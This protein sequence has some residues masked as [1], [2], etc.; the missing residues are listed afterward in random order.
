VKLTLLTFLLMGWCT[1]ALCQTG[2]LTGTILDADSK[3]SLEFATINIL[4]ADSTLV[5]YKLTDKEGKFL[6]DKLPVRRKLFV[7]VTYTG[8]SEYRSAIELQPGK[9]DTLQ[10][11]LTLNTK[12]SNGV[13]VTAAVPVRMNGDTLEINPAAFKMKPDAVVEEL[14]NQVGGVVIWSDGSIT[15]NGRKVQNLMVDGKPFMGSTD[16]RVATQN[17]PKAAIDKIQLYQEYDRSNISS[18]Q[19][20]PQDSVLTMNIK[21]KEGSKKGYFGKAGGGLGTSQRFESDLSFQVYNKQ[22]SAGIGGGYNNI[23][24]SIGNLQELF[25]NNTYRNYNPNL[26]NVGRFGES[27]IN[28]NH[29]IGGVVT[30]SFIKEA[31]GR[32]NNRLAVN[33]IKSGVSS[34]ITDLSLQN[35]TTINNPQFI[36]EEGVVNNVTDKHDVGINYLKTNSYSDNLSVNGA[37]NTTSEWANSAQL[38]EVRD[39]MNMLQSTNRSTSTQHRR[40]DNE[41][42]NVDFSKSDPEEPLNSYSLRLHANRG[43]TTS[44]RDVKSVFESLV[45]RSKNTLYNRHYNVD[46]QLVNLGATLDYTGFKRMLLG[47]YNLFGINLAFS[48]QINYLQQQ[49]DNRVADFDSTAKKF[50]TNGNLTYQNKRELREYMPSLRLSKDINKW[51][52]LFSRYLGFQVSIMEDIKSDKNSSTNAKRNLDRSFQFFR[53][54]GNINYQYNKQQKYRAYT[55][56]SYSKNFDYPTIDQLYTIVDDINVYDTR[57]GNPFLRNRINHNFYLLGNFNTENPGAVYTFSG[58]LTGGYNRSRYPIV[59]STINDPSGRRINYYINGDKSSTINFSS[60]LSLSRRLKKSVIQLRYNSLFNQNKYPNYVDGVYNVSS[61]NSWSNTVS[62][63]FTL[64]SILVLNVDRT[65]QDYTTKQTAAGLN[66]FKN[67]NRITKFGAVLNYPSHFTFSSTLDYI[68]NSNLNKPTNLWNAFA[69]YRFMQQQAEVKFSAMDILKQYRNIS[70][71]VNTYGTITRVT[72]GLQQFFL[73]TFSY[74]PRKFGKTE[75]KR[76]SREVV[77]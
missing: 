3:T 31:N 49:E 23:N 58:N 1:V 41:S 7:S 53:Y 42:L 11:L 18:Q 4:G 10:V 9:I 75:I 19:R 67:A 65:M 52:E 63:Q 8:Y 64:R 73:L 28:K 62:L 66:S 39:S 29:S 40:T 37:V 70:N 60:S 26:Y 76:Q 6:L 25:Q 61:T 77:Y 43:N 72:N 57:V 56:L 14:L 27:G 68:D 54:E 55:Y 71:S 24:K 33:Y 15:V 22:T 35:R 59:D 20:K 32:Q 34:Y 13:V 74:Y 12:D 45:D 38:T 36:R 2:T 21:L 44:D 69:T 30:H 50:V 16:P 17:L 46:N 48:Q 51:T 47:R 5:S